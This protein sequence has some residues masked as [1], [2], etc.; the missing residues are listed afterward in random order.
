MFMVTPV[1]IAARTTNGGLGRDGPIPTRRGGRSETGTWAAVA[2]ADL[3]VGVDL[4]Q[5]KIQKKKQKKA[6]KHVSS[7]RTK[8]KTR[9]APCDEEERFLVLSEFLRCFFFF[10]FVIVDIYLL[11]ERKQH[12]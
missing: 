3:V 6:T 9:S 2:P 10:I 11:R 1:V 5:N 7:E 4:I 8:R 12:I